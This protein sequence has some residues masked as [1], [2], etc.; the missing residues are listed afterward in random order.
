MSALKNYKRQ[1]YLMHQTHEASYYIKRAEELG[2][3][4]SWIT[5]DAILEFLAHFRNALNA[6]AKC[7]VSAGLGRTKLEKSVFGANTDLLKKHERIMDLRHKYVAH[8][9]D[10]EFESVS[11]KE[12]DEYNVMTLQLQ[13]EISFPFDRLYELR[14]LIKYIEI[15]IVDRQI[16]HVAA[17]ERE[18]GKPVLIK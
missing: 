7:F 6:Y 10:N 5:Y 3:P 4:Q 16:S 15:H 13:Y 8:S 18:I 17:I 11:V 12:V 9:D 2:H 1:I 14:E